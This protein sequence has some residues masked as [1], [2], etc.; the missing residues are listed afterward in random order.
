[1][2]AVDGQELRRRRQ[3]AGLTGQELAA[4]VGIHS[5]HLSKVELGHKELSIGK[6]Q[7]VARALACSTDE[8]L[9]EAS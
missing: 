3:A 2:R 4:R 1:M 6:L 9:R 5:A 8:L 7:A